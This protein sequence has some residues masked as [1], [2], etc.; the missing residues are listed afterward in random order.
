MEQGE[1]AG[2]TGFWLPER[3]R[4][5]RLGNISEIAVTDSDGLR[6]RDCPSDIFHNPKTKESKR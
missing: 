4:M 2:Q 6:F 5:V 1:V 3:G